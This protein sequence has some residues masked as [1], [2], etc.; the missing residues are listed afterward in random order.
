MREVTREEL[1]FFEGRPES[2]PIYLAFAGRLF[3]ELPDTGMRV[4]KTQITFTNPRV[5]ACASFLC[6]LRKAE[7]PN[8][9]LT[10]TLGLSHPLDSPRVSAQSEPY[11]GRWTTHFVIGSPNELDDELFGW[12][13]EAYGFAASKRRRTR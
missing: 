10:I 4:Q 12:V 11:P 9:F 2:L 7:M 5:Y 1:A 13:H 3:D 8:P 6:A